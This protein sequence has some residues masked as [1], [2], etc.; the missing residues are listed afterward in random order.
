[1]PMNVGPVIQHHLWWAT[2]TEG[3]RRV[4]TLKRLFEVGVRWQHS[5]PEE[6]GAVRRSLL[7]TS[8]GTFVELVK[9]LAMD[10]YCST[11]VLKEL[12]RTP[13]M[14][15]RMQKVGFIP[16]SDERHRF[17][18]FR[19]TG[20]RDV[21][22]RFGVQVSEP[23]G[24]KVTAPTRPRS[25][26]LAR[27]TPSGE[28]IQLNRDELFER[29]WSRP[30]ATVAKDIGISG[31]GLKKVCRRLGVPVPPRGYWAKL[32]AGKHVR[33]PTLPATV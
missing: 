28:T 5:T 32:R 6:I 29:V 26:R 7:K 33:R 15:E 3:S 4:A 21:L 13:S 11:Q 30:V 24:P 8:N 31:P 9:L 1:L 14:R 18:Q 10:D 19:P 2:F 12:A 27:R 17:N 20:S 22:K 23:K 16:S 25:V